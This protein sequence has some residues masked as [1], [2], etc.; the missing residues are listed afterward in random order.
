M[1]HFIRRLWQREFLFL[2]ATI[3]LV[4]VAGVI[5]YMTRATVLRIAVAPRDGTEPALIQAYADAL[6]GA[7]SGIQLDIVN[8]DDVTDSAK[9]LQEGR[10]DLAVV[11]PDV[12]MPKNGLTVLILRDQAMVVAAPPGTEVDGFASLAGKRLG[13]AAHRDDDTKVI[14]KVL[15]YFGL[16]LEGGQTHP[17][18]RAVGLVPVE[19]NGVADAFRAKQIDAF[20][21][22]IAPSAPKAIELVQKL[23]SLSRGGE[24]AFLEV[25]DDGAVIE[26]FPELQSVTIPGGLF[27]GRP[28]LPKDDVKTVGASYRLM[29]SSSVSRSVVADL[30]Q[31][32]FELRASAASATDAANYIKA[33]SYETTV[34]ATSAT[35][36]NHP[37]ALDYYERD[38]HGFF[39]RYGDT[40][41]LLGAMLGGLASAGA[42]VSERMSRLK[43]ERIDDV[44][45]RLLKITAEARE[46]DDPERMADLNVEIDKLAMDAVRYARDRDPDPGTIAAVSIAIDTARATVKDCIHASNAS[47]VPVAE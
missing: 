37:G 40:L 30:T 32:F 33:P 8:F 13:I 42:W 23:K 12:L 38:Q 28:K 35:T 45:D 14:A 43:R 20:V 15:G 11:R 9:A 3:A 29:A 47:S 24:V 10:A 7:K 31:A 39:E 4:V 18:G 5:F 1:P 22:I 2:I 46:M 19:E 41:Y 34:S 6:R 27:G 25:V 26:R 44:M 17:Q 36:P 21:S 16:N